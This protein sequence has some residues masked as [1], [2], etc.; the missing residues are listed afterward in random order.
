M[1]SI[2]QWV[3]WTERGA[4]WI[5]YYDENKTDEEQ[6]TSPDD[7]VAGKDITVF[8]YKKSDHFTLPSASDAWESQVPEIPEQFHDALVNKAIAIGYEKSPEGIP[9]AQYFN[10]K[11]E[12]DVKNGRKYAYRGRTG[13][14]KEIGATD[15]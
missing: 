11:F 9:M 14:F 8:Y 1:S 2:R 12:D 3:W 10:G 13:T 6:F 7:T 15:F 4:I 5:G